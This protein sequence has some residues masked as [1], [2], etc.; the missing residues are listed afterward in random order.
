MMGP[1]ASVL[2]LFGPAELLGNLLGC[3]TR[4]GRDGGEPSMMV[5]VSSTRGIAARKGA[6]RRFGAIASCS[7]V[8]R[9]VGTFEP[10]TNSMVGIRLRRSCPTG[11]HQ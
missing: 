9:A 3:R 6:L 4:P 7:A 1:H 11:A 8:I 10:R 2:A 5:A